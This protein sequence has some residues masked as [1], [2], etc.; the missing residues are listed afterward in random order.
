MDDIEQFFSLNRSRLLAF[1]DGDAAAA[2]GDDDAQAFVD[3]VL[4]DWHRL[5]C[6]RKLPAPSAAERTFWFALYQ[7]EELAELPGGYVDPYVGFATGNLASARECLREGRGLPEGLFASRPG[8]HPANGQTRG[9][10]Q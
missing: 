2:T 7:L 5:T 1:L 4:H 8:E 3:Q 9:D 6:R 10:R